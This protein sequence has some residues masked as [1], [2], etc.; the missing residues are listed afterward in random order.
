MIKYATKLNLYNEATK[1]SFTSNDNL[2][3]ME[4]LNFL[5]ISNFEFSGNLQSKL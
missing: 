3:I 4:N 5:M 1:Y 2:K